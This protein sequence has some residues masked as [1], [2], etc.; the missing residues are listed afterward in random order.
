VAEE[1]TELVGET[2]VLHLR[3]IVPANAADIY[4]KLEYLN[5]GGSIKDRAALGMI[6]RAEKDGRLQPGA[7]IF[8]AT[9]GNTGVGL[10]L[11]GIGRGYQVVLAVPEKFSQEKVE[12]M[13]A[14]GAEVIRTPDADGMQGAINYVKDRA[15]KTPNS[16]VAGQFENQDNP[17][18]HYETTAHEFYE[19]MQGRVDAVVIG[20][21]TGGTFSGIAR[22]FKEQ[23]PSVLAVVVEP[24]GSILSGPKGN[25]STEGIGVSFIPKTYHGR[26]VDEIIAVSDHDAFETVKKLAALEGV[27]GGSS[28][29]ANVFAAL[30]IARR[31]GPGKRVATIIPDSAERYLS[32]DIFHFNDQEENH[33]GSAAPVGSASTSASENER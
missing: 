16:F 4:A 1:I 9:A 11:I 6:Q 15:D 18:F 13:K 5:P 2:P 19:Q 3:K 20:V 28:A 31:L 29:G 8:E 10:A 33:G 21:G 23:N 25:Y 14:L 17:E 27:L 24:V 7:T 26:L 22:Y 30:Q 12:L 32:K